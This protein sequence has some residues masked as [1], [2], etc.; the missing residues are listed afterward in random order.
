MSIIIDI[1]GLPAL[2]RVIEAR[3]AEAERILADPGSSATLR[4]LARRFVA[5][6]GGL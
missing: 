3:R 1:T 5:Q 2:R 4:D 6:H